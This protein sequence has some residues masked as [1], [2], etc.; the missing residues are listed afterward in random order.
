MVNL[1]ARLVRKYGG[2]QWLDPDDEYS[3]RTAHPDMMYFQKDRG[4]NRYVVFAMKEGYDLNKIPSMQDSKWE[5][6]ETNLVQAEVKEFYE[7]R[8]EVKCY[9]KEEDDCDS[10]EE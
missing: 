5:T 7:D 1:Q 6:W 8:R 4:N 2:L 9:N 10:D 3:I